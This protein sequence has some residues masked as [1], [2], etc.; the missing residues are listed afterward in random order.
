M[1]IPLVVILVVAVTLL[2]SIPAIR[3]VL[4]LDPAEVLH[5]R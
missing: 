3:T 4:R 2:G 1:V 5:G